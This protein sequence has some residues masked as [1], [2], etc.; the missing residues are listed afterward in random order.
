MG[1]V[2]SGM[3]SMEQEGAEVGGEIAD[4][5]AIAVGGPAPQMEALE[6]D[7]GPGRP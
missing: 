1:L 7:V 5:D 6:E 3:G 4:E 2:G